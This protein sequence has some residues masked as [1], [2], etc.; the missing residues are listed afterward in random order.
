MHPRK[1]CSTA[2][3]LTSLNPMIASLYHYLPEKV[4]TP[5][6]IFDDVWRKNPHFGPCVRAL[7][8]ELY[9]NGGFTKQG[10]PVRHPTGKSVVVDF[11]DPG[12]WRPKPALLS[13]LAL[14][15]ANNVANLPKQGRR[16]APRQRDA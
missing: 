14:G 1:G 9:G 7:R 11:F 13:Y 6:A 10:D 12:K 15:T 3:D 8:E 16:D 2:G 5:E 4:I